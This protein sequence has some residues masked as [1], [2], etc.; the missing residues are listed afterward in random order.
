MFQ[1]KLKLIQSLWIQVV[2]NFIP[3]PRFQGSVS[4]LSSNFYI[5]LDACNHFTKQDDSPQWF[6]VAN[7]TFPDINSGSDC[8]LFKQPGRP[9]LRNL[10]RSDL[11]DLL[12]H[13]KERPPKGWQR[14]GQRIESWAEKPLPI[15]AGSYGERWIVHGFCDLPCAAQQWPSWRIF[16]GEPDQSPKTGECS[17]LT[18]I[19]S[20]A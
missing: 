19:Q 4:N 20:E 12:L 5:P 6:G 14:H 16:P 2:L 11:N 15:I 8:F 13:R 10:R 3:F 9:V 18:Q 7:D 17:C 1:K